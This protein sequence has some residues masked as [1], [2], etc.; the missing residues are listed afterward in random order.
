VEK[1]IKK[2]YIIGIDGGGTKTEA[3]LADLH[4]KIFK[5]AKA[6]S[7]SPRNV[8]IKK[9]VEN[10]IEVIKKV[11]GVKEIDSIFVGMPA[12]EEEYKLKKETIKRE[13]LKRLKDFKGKL[14]IVSDQLVAFRSGTDKKDGIVLIAGTGCVCHGWR[15]KKEAKTSGWGWLADE[16]S[17]FWTGQKGFQAV[18]KELDGRGPKTLITKTLFKEWKIKNKTDLLNKVY[19]NFSIRQ[20]SLIS[21]LVDKAADRGDK[22]ARDIMIKAGKELTQSA[23]T[24]IKKLNFQNEKFPIVLVGGMFDSKTVSHFFKREVKKIAKKTQFLRAKV[25]PVIGAVKLAI[26]QLTINPVRKRIF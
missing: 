5:I 8:G 3:A 13:I 12:V 25:G 15:E 16:G 14:I 18:L 4:G 24:V 26:E 19:L 9:A 21:K 1:E 2:Q 22:V 6:G 23:I 11:K 7:A 17:G 20:I 10:I